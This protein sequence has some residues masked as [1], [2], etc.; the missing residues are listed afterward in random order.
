MFDHRAYVGLQVRVG[1]A[2][3]QRRIP[4]LDGQN[5]QGPKDFPGILGRK[6]TEKMPAVAFLLLL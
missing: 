6:Y 2:H 4:D 3:L 1:V 5:V